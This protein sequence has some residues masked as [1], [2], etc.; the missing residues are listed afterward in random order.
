MGLRKGLEKKASGV[1]QCPGV[2][3]R[4][5]WPA[6]VS[7]SLRMPTSGTSLPSALHSREQPS[8]CPRF[9]HVLCLLALPQAGPVAPE[10]DQDHSARRFQSSSHRPP[11]ACGCE[12]AAPEPH[13]CV[14]CVH[15]TLRCSSVTPALGISRSGWSQPLADFLESVSHATVPV[16]FLYLYLSFTCRLTCSGCRLDRLLFAS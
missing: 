8:G 1:L 6:K 15:S 10:W 3:A 4:L 7:A 13:C 5:A 14:D 2:M 9:L 11:V 12:V 16:T